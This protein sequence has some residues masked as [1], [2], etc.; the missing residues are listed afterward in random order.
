MNMT[1]RE[2]IDRELVIIDTI[3]RSQLGEINSDRLLIGEPKYLRFL[4]SVQSDTELF[5]IESYISHYSKRIEKSIN[6]TLLQ[7]ELRGYHKRANELIDLFNFKLTEESVIVKAYRD[8]LPESFEEKLDYQ[9]QHS[10]VVLV[11]HLKISKIIFGAFNSFQKDGFSWETRN[12]NYVSTN[13]ELA[14]FCE[15]LCRF[16]ADCGIIKLKNNNKLS[17]DSTDKGIEKCFE[18]GWF[19]VGLKFASGEAQLAANRKNQEGLSWDY[20]TKE[21]GL[22]PKKHR[23][24]LSETWNDTNK[25]SDK[26]IYNNKDKVTTIINYCEENGITVVDDFMNKLSFD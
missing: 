21:L 17:F 6:N 4:F 20:V 15:K 7:N 25:T 5:K 10:A 12:H 8:N 2:R 13:Y 19:E 16:V 26:N 22:D 9:N 14:I 24:Y 1:V 3:F 23:P 11:N 18:S